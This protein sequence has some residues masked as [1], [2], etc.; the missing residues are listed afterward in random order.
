MTLTP[1]IKGIITAALMI[2]IVFI[3][4]YTNM[5]ADSPFQYL[6]YALYALGIVWTIVAY[7]QSAA[8]TGKFGDAFSQGFRCFIVVTLLMVLFTFAFNKM[9]P[10]FAAESAQL[11]KEQQLKEKNK[12]LPDIEAGVARYKKGYTMALVYGSIFGYLIIG[13]GVTAAVSALITRRK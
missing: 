12:L 13:A 10:E 4:F 9:H 3:T 2:A 5:P 6:V 11:Y 8:F 7:R 1:A